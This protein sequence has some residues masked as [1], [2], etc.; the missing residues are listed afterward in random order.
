MALPRINVQPGELYLACEPAILQ[1][2]LGSCVSVTFWSPR[3]GVG[4]LCHGVLPR[5]PRGA[6]APDGHHYVDFAIRHLVRKFDE[7]GA[8][9]REVEIKVFGGGDVLPV[10]TFRTSRPTVGALNCQAALEVLDEEGFAVLASDLG[11][12][13]GRTIRFHTAT[14]EVLVH[15]LERLGARPRN[16]AVAVTPAV[17]PEAWV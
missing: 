4:A 2:I 14:G 16:Y 6:V 10:G 1:T 17:S 9:R 13:R 3:L 7:L 5:S 15:R 11:G 12:T 8:A